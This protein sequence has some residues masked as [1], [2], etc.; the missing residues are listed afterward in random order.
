MAPSQPSAPLINYW[1]DV[2][3]NANFVELLNQNDAV[4]PWDYPD[5]QPLASWF[6]QHFVQVAGDQGVRLYRK[7]HAHSSLGK[8][9]KAERDSAPV[10]G[11]GSSRCQLATLSLE[12]P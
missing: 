11:L 12:A 3:S 4:V 2:L 1:K 8:R 7:R 10:C 5:Q 9:P 6:D